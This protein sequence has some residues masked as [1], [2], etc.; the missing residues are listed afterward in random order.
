MSNSITEKLLELVNIKFSHVKNVLK[1][2]YNKI[3]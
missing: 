2:W 3:N 1:K